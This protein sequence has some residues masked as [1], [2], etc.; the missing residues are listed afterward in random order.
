MREEAQLGTD[1]A[2][3]RATIQLLS[4]RRVEA[5]THGAALRRTIAADNQM[6]KTITQRVEM[7]ESLEGKG[8][9]TRSSV[10]D[11][12]EDLDRARK[13][14]VA[15]E[16]EL[17]EAGASASTI[18]AEIN[19][20]LHA[21][22]VTNMDAFVEAQTRADA[23]EQDIVKAREK[24]DRTRI[25]APIDG[26][27]Q[28]LAVTTVGQ[29][30]QAGQQLMTIVPHRAALQIEALVLNRDIGFVRTG[31]KAVV[32]VE[33][34]PFTRYGVLEAN[35]VEVSRDAVAS[36]EATAM[37]STQMTPIPS[38]AS[39]AAPVTNAAESVYPVLL[40]LQRGFLVVD[41]RR[42]PL[43]PGMS[44]T[45]EIKTGRRRLLEYLLSPILVSVDQAAHE[46]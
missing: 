43:K 20:K 4:A 37:Q 15:E 36:R 13:S 30:V 33:S 10:V 19:E 14:T 38:D 12:R 27:A 44:V 23:I 40:V 34:F 6:L 41:G 9:G 26:T 2:E 28:E 3:L 18:E 42:Q 35:V 8:F 32:K 24:L 39:A 1:L 16:G 22:A 45:V 7:R 17:I 31:Q 25:T 5:E 46:R 29:I 21:F 11:A